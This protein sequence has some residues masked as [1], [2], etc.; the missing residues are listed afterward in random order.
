MNATGS[1]A[2]QA[3]SEQTTLRLQLGIL[4]ARL[5]TCQEIGRR[6][7]GVRP[8]QGRNGLFGEGR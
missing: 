2:T 5:R 8:L 7:Q 1:T 3:A 6:R 4:I